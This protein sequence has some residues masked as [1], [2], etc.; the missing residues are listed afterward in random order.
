MT[1][2]ISTRH[3]PEQ[4]RHRDRL[5]TLRLMFTARFMRRRIVERLARRL[6]ASNRQASRIAHYIP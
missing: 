4:A 6:G 1:R 2:S 3:A 5:S